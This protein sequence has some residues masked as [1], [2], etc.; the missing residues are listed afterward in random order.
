MNISNPIKLL[1]GHI[2]GDITNQT[3]LQDALALKADLSGATFDGDVVVNGE[4]TVTT[5]LVTSIFTNGK[6]TSNGDVTAPNLAY[7]ANNFTTDQI[8]RTL[9]TAFGTTY[10]NHGK[11]LILVGGNVQ[12]SE[13]TSGSA[14]VAVD[15]STR[16][17]IGNIGVGTNPSAYG[18]S[19]LFP[20]KM[21]SS[22]T[23]TST[24]SVTMINYWYFGGNIGS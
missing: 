11:G 10:T 6:I 12:T 8:Y 20:V 15:G 4:M 18:I 1:W 24:G 2:R 14:L 22:W 23:I 3:D 17:H 16:L 7:G 13:T 21:G 9:P 19:F 5:P